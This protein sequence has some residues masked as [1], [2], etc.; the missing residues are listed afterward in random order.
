MEVYPSWK[1]EYLNDCITTVRCVVS[2]VATVE[3]RLV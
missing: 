1:I 3:S 2:K